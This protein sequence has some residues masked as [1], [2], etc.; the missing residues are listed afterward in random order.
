M[1]VKG[2]C[3]CGNIQ[4]KAIVDLSKVYACHCTDCQILSG[5]P[6]RTMITVDNSNVDINGDIKEYIKIADSGNE[7]IQAF[8]MNCCTSLYSSSMQKD[9]LSLRTGIFEQR[10]QFIPRKH[11][12]GRSSVKWIHSIINDNWVTTMPNSEK[13]KIK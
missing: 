6:F 10:N 12:Y 7:R 3:H 13:Y 5:G 11:L 4:I 2:K 1:K 9:K 8:C